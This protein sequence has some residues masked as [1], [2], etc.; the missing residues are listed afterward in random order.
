MAEGDKQ[1]TID[2]E[3]MLAN[4]DP[5]KP[6]SLETWIQISEMDGDDF[7]VREVEK[8]VVFQD[9][10]KAYEYVRKVESGYCALIDYMYHILYINNILAGI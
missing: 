2:S 9:V 8:L 1:E 6:M 4:W 3:D 7:H 5:D 10:N